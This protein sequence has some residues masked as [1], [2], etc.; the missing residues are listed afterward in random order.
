MTVAIRD[1]CVLTIANGMVQNSQA[2][3]IVGD[4]DVDHIKAR[5]SRS[6]R[7]IKVP[8]NAAKV[9]PGLVPDR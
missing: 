7:G 4:V 3:I 9:I 1:S 8:A 5:S 6:S 2:I